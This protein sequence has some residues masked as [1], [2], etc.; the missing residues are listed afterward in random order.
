MPGSPLRQ[1][2]A[3]ILSKTSRALKRPATLPVRGLTNSYSSS[4]SRARMNS[5]VRPTEMLKLLKVP[6]CSLQVIKS[7]TSGWSTRRMP[8]FAPR[9]LPPC[10]ITSVAV[11]KTRMKEMGPEAMPPVEPTMSPEGRKREKEKPVPPPD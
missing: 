3:A 5:S 8:M 11:S 9:L 2:P 1:A 4:A 10:L 6:S 7:R